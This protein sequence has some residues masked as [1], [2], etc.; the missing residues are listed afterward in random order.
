LHSCNRRRKKKEGRRRRRRRERKKKP[1]KFGKI[2]EI[3]LFKYS[4]K[5]V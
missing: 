5:A 1:R 3:A 2:Y 4:I